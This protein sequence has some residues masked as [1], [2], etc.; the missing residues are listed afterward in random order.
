[1]LRAQF[2]RFLL[3][4]GLAAVANIFSRYLLNF[5]MSYVAAIIVAYLI[6][7]VT[8]FMLNRQ[9]VFPNATNKVRDQIWWFVLI[10]IAAL[11]QTLAVSLALDRIVLPWVGW[12]FHPETIAHMAGV[13]VPVFTSYL[14]HRHWTF[15]GA[16]PS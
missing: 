4:G 14:G 5:T 3:A 2:S 11:L 8:A 15:A 9:F 13:M 7:M 16:K 10:N 6:G 1:M 12:T